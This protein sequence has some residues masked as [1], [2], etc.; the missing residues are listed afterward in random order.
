MDSEEHYFPFNAS[1][2]TNK[3][4]FLRNILKNPNFIKLSDTGYKSIY[5]IFFYKFYDKGE[6]D[7]A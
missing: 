5:F 7:H 1:I 6:L 3:I 4:L 2:S